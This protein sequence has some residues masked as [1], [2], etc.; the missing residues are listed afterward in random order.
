MLVCRN[1]DVKTLQQMLTTDPGKACR[2]FH[3]ALHGQEMTLLHVAAENGHEACIRTLLDSG[4]DI[5]AV[6]EDHW[7][8]VNILEWPLP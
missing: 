7:E 5:K 4:A 3:S 1:N 8:C 6:M 2:L